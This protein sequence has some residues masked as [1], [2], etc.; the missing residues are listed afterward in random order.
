MASSKAEN[1]VFYRFLLARDFANALTCRV[2]LSSGKPNFGNTALGL[3]VAT[4][5]FSHQGLSV[6]VPISLSGVE[7]SS[8]PDLLQQQPSTAKNST[9]QDVRDKIAVIGSSSTD[10]LD[11]ETDLGS[12]GSSFGGPDGSE[13]LS[14]PRLTNQRP[15]TAEDVF[16][17]DSIVG[18]YLFETALSRNE[19]KSKGKKPKSTKAA[20][21][22]EIKAITKALADATYRF[23]GSGSPYFG[24]LPI[25]L[26]DPVRYWI[27]YYKTNGRQDFLVWLARGKALAEHVRPT[28]REQGIP[29]EFFYLAMI[30]SGF[31]N[32]AYSRA[33]ASGTWQFMRRT[34]KNYGLL[35]DHWVDER[36]DPVR[37]TVAAATYL[38]D[39]YRQLGDWH[40]AMAAYNA[41]PGRI[42]RAMLKAK[43]QSFWEL[44]ETKILAR[45]TRQYVP[46]VLAAVLLAAFPEAHGFHLQPAP[47]EKW[48][49]GIV[50]VDRP[51]LLKEIAEHL[52]IELRDLK[53]W[54]PE[55]MRDITPPGRP[56]YS[57][58]LPGQAV[59]RFP[60]I[61]TQLSEIAIEDVALHK[62]KSGDTLS[63]L[64]Q[65]YGTKVK[66]I[67]SINPGLKA[68]RLRVGKT[69]AIPVPATVKVQARNT[70]EKA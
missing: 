56:A 46:K 33:R 30:E 50:E 25:T 61:H 65:R 40:L 5:G 2:R 43:T 58:R 17:P 13:S 67:L 54:N 55:L 9:G 34:A 16:C 23:E 32:R 36:R 44:A 69:V 31:S 4:F 12:R 35:I 47:A 51:I 60:K 10:V 7:R 21:K 29:M 14:P 49:L 63:R 26:N 66:R 22:A 27:N 24:S 62:V 38:K 28:L 68:D 53:R 52:R 45:E 3:F 39:L 57:L 64:A 42:R 11:R 37:S 41:G 48:P 19:D 20:A 1:W 59:S 6:S 70:A 8:K 18:R 15:F